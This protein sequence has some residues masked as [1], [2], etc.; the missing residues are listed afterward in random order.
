MLVLLLSVLFFLPTRIL[1]DTKRGDEPRCQQECLREHTEKMG[2]LS[3]EYAKTKDKRGYQDQVE[4]ELSHY[5]R[6]LTNC[7]EL[8]PIK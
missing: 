6:C 7:R 4:S 5:S 2:L 1:A 3:E 8:L